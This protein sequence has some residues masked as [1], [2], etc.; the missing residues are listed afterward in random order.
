MMTTTRTAMHSSSATSK[1][2]QPVSNM[3]G[4]APAEVH[5]VTLDVT[6]SQM[7]TASFHL[8]G[9]GGLSGG[10]PETFQPLQGTGWLM[11]RASILTP[12]SS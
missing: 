1:E 10:V 5:A 11:S 4:V 12:A 3:A 9:G 8:G 2:I 6:H 7:M